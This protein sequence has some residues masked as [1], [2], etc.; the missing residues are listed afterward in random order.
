M[1]APLQLENY[2]IRYFNFEVNEAFFSDPERVTETE[3]FFD[4]EDV[5]FA[6][7]RAV[8]PSSE[9]DVGF[10]QVRIRLNCDEEAFE[11]N[12]IKVNLSLVGRF[13]LERRESAPPE[14]EK[15]VGYFL[16]NGMSI[17]YGIA[18]VLIRQMVDQSPLR[19][20]GSEIILPT[21]NF[22]DIT[23]EWLSRNEEQLSSLAPKDSE[24]MPK[25]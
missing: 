24:E 9:D 21:T 19:G 14:I 18:R 10:I 6:I 11:A 25:E 16:N 8:I 7:E 13:R 22:V 20:L 15:L 17:L 5:G 23:K 2:V 3:V 4:R 1:L 12:L